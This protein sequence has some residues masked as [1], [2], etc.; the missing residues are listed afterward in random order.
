MA[1]VASKN[2]WTK[3]TRQE[4]FAKQGKAPITVKWLDVNKGDD[5]SP[6]YRSRLVAREVRRPWEP[7]M[8]APTPPLEALRSVLSLA[9]TNLPGT[10]EHVRDGAA[11]TRTQI[12]VIDIKRAYFNARTDED[13]PTYVELPPEDPDCARGLCA[14]LLVHMYG[15]R[16]AG[17]GWHAEYSEFLV[18]CIGFERGGASPCLF[19]HPKRGIVTSVYGDDFT[20]AGRKPDLDWFREKLEKKY[21]LVEAARLGPGPRDDKAARVLNRVVRWTESGLEYEAD[22]RQAEQLCRDLGLIG[23]KPL[24]TPGAKVNSEQLMGDKPLA[25][26]KATPFRAVAARANY[27]AADR[28]EC[29]FAAKEICRWMAAPTDCSLG[30]LKRLGRYIEGKRRLVYHYPWQ[31][32]DR[33]LL[34]HRLVGLSKDAQK[35]QRRVHCAW[36]A[37]DQVLELHPRP[38]ISVLWRGRVLWRGESNWKRAGFSE[39]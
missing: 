7:S 24:G 37:L 2:V 10:Q 1:Y 28:P 32:A 23:A 21:E 36:T 26:E 12:S 27:L 6:N 29:Q 3:A 8:F 17:D 22:P 15:T 25:A 38:G 14:R 31:Q 9:A 4:A 35:H 16:A 18:N 11:S 20:T 34:G 33:R 13:S 5:E 30:A 39:T 19:R